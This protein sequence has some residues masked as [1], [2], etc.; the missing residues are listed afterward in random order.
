[1]GGFSVSSIGQISQSGL[2]E[3]KELYTALGLL[4]LVPPSFLILISFKAK[5][6]QFYLGSVPLWAWVCGGLDR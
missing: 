5:K 6:S 1:M 4:A 3:G 2:V